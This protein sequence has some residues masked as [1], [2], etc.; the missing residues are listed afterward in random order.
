MRL[1][2]QGILKAANAEIER[3]FTDVEDQMLSINHA[4]VGAELA[5][6]SVCLE[7]CYKTIIGGD[8]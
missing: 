4:I 8:H 3:P 2:Y 5:E 6:D 7:E 1:E